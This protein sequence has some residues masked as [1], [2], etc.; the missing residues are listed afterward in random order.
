VSVTDIHLAM[1]WYRDTLGMAVLAE[2]ALVSAHAEN[3]SDRDSHLASVVREIFGPRLGKFMICHLVSSSGSGVELFEFIEPAAERRESGA[4]FEYWKSGFFHLAIT[5]PDVE[6]LA[7]KIA[8]NGGKQRTAT[9]ELFPG[10]GKKIC[11]CEDPFGNIIEI[12]SHSY[13]EFW[14]DKG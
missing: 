1:R 12:Y 3:S 5:D 10:S 7:Q 9:M 4:N 11:F 2:P 14:Q 8:E 13:L 6:G